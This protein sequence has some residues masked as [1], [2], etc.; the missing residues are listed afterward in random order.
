[1]V[2]LLLG[3]IT[4]LWAILALRAVRGMNGLPRLPAASLIPDADCPP[5]SI[6]FSA[7]DEAEQL[8]QAL[9]SLLTQDY[10][11]YQ[12]IAVDDRSSDATGR[13]LDEFAAHSPRLQ[14]IHLTEL[15]SGW[16]GKPHGLQCAYEASSG[17][18]LVFTDADVRFEPE[19]LRRAMALVLQQYRWDHLTLLGVID[20]VGFWE[21]VALTYFTAGFILGV[22]PW[23]VSDP[24]SRHYFGAG[25]FQ[26]IRRSAYEA[27]GTHRRLALEVVDDMKLG[28]LVKQGGFR[29]SVAS[30]GEAVAV[31]WH[32]GLA[33]IIRGT[34]KNFF[35]AYNFNPGRVLMSMLG[36]IVMSLLPVAAVLVASDLLDRV[37]GL[38]A[39][40]IAAGLQG[41]SARGSGRSVLYGLTH[42]LG[43]VIF[44]YML[45]RSMAVTLWRGGVLWRD[46]FYPLEQLKRGRV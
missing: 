39:T 19:V 17:A 45:A 40:V 13:I 6:L 29:S 31:R 33:N 35:A 8:P 16:L 21:K 14:V 23:R 34:T 43:T 4:V 22:Q 18:W 30:A 42:P 11:H 25:M 2:T 3:A 24:H 12:V 44:C 1:M 36:L 37:L 9:A 10:P 46:T 15:P 26:L 38:T 32:A 28:K 7:R 41:Y 5:V 20:M 27:I